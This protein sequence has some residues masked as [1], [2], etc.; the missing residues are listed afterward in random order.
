MSSSICS[1]PEGFYNRVLKTLLAVDDFLMTYPTFSAKSQPYS[2]VCFFVIRDKRYLMYSRYKRKMGM[3]GL[4]VEKY[5]H[6]FLEV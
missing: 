6:H 5:Y 3:I 2:Y 1:I 4:S